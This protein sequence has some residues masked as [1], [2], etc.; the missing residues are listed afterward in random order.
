M[1]D[2]PHEAWKSVHRMLDIAIAGYL[3]AHPGRMPSTITVMELVQWS[4]EQ[5]KP[6]TALQIQR[7]AERIELERQEFLKSV[8]PDRSEPAT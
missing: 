8:I 1:S 7:E 5:T 6:K 3:K 2:Q 4:F